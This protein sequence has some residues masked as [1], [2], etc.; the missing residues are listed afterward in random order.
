MNR[1]IIPVAS[2]LIASAVLAAGTTDM[3]KPIELP[4]AASEVTPEFDD[5]S[6][7]VLPEVETEVQADSCRLNPDG[8]WSCAP[9]RVVNRSASVSVNR[10]STQ[11]E[12]RTLFNR[13][14]TRQRCGLFGRR[15]R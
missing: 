3:S 14:R 1:G 9:R 6:D 10:A 13:T 4:A 5:A 15:C 7:D 8:T 12:R 2:I 11:R